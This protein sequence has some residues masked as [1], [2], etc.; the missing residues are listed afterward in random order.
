[1]PSHA[2]EDKLSPSSTPSN[3]WKAPIQV[4]PLKEEGKD[5]YVPKL[6]TRNDES[7]SELPD[8]G[9]I[10]SPTKRNKK[11]SFEDMTQLLSEHELQT[12]IKEARCEPS[13]PISP[14]REALG[15]LDLDEDAD[16]L[17]QSHAIC[18]MCG[19]HVDIGF[20]QSYSGGERMNIKKQ[21]NF[22]QAHKIRS[23]REEWTTRG[24][25]TIDWTTLDQ[26]IQSHH[27]FLKQILDGHQSY[28]RNVLQDAVK[29][30]KGRTLRQDI[31]GLGHTL[32]PGYYGP[33]G[34]RAMSENIMTRFSPQLRR[35]AVKDR[36]VS[37][38][39]VTGYVQAVLVPELAV[40]LIGED[41]GIGVEETRRVMDDSVALGD[42]LND[43]L[44][45]V[46]VMRDEHYEDGS[47]FDHDSFL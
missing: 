31:F 38:R 17:C 28:Y 37:A 8:I 47:T 1:M 9:D 14:S 27:S 45:E 7:D 21:D 18:P 44:D 3:K 33:R 34:L 10:R 30:G 22:C 41:L 11:R 15:S 26:R 43:E 4:S 2:F 12:M 24:Y 16:Q 46:V 5:F 23:A 13:H 19:D 42:L 36:L 35:I 39:G 20:L 25:P 40:R 29:T 6:P 32:T